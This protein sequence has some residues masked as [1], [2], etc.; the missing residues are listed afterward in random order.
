MVTARLVLH[1]PARLAL[2]R[3]RPILLLA[4]VALGVVVAPSIALAQQLTLSWA[5][6][7]GGQASFIIQRAS[8]TTGPYNQIALVP[9]GITSYIDK[10]VSPGATYCYQVA[11]VAGAGVSPF[12]NVACGSPAAGF[13]VTVAT[14]GTGTG[15]VVSAPAG[16]TCP[17][18]CVQSY[19][20]STVL[21]LT[22]TPAAGSSFTGWSGGGCGGAGSCVLAGNAPV[23]VIATFAKNSTAPTPSIS[24]LNPSSVMAGGPAFSLT[25]TGSGFVSGATATVG[26]QA[27]TVTFGSATQ[28]TIAVSATDI[29]NSGA[30]PVQISNTAPCAGGLC[31]SN[32][33]P[34]TVT[35]PTPAPTLSGISPSTAIAGTSAF[36][37]TATGTNFTTNSVV[38]VN[39][40][41]RTTSFVSA[42]QVTAA[43]LAS[44]IAAAGTASITVVTP[45]PG[46]GTSGAQPLTVLGPSL[47]V[48]AT[49]V[50]PGGTAT[51]TLTNSSGGSTDWLTLAQ[52][53]ATDTSYLQWVYVGA[54]LSTRTW[55]VTMPTTLGQYEFRFYPNN[56]FVR[57]AT[58]P[59]VTVTAVTSTPSV[60]SASQPSVTL[61]VTGNPASGPYAVEA[62]TTL[63]GALTVNFFVDGSFVHQESVAKYCLFGGDG[64]CGTGRLGAGTHVIKA[65]M[66]RQGASTVLAETQITVTEG[67]SSSASAGAVTLVVTGNPASGPYAVEAQS[68]L[69]GPLIMNFLVDG[70]FV[71][72]ESVSKYCLFG[73]DTICSAGTLGAGAHVIKAQALAPGSAAVLAETY[74]TVTE[75]S[76]AP[77]PS[78]V[79]LVVTGNPATGPYAV[80]ARTTLTGALTVNFFVDG[81][82]VHQE[83]IA[84]YCLFGGDTLCGPGRLGAGVHAIKAQ[85]L[86]QGGS[87]VLAETQITVTE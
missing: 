16:I 81:T 36:T 34:L 14:S 87:T 50:A 67:A 3:A 53:G 23:S 8:G 85:V 31:T 26:G 22:A 5:D 80:E 82:F 44:D 35:A 15:T 55:I 57:A 7:S 79:T 41:P 76:S 21:T 68:P 48:N 25:V 9:L 11:A 61:V 75:G 71:H 56:G 6:T 77:P 10:T 62:Q 12:S 73:S 28:L 17:G 37:L 78:P 59:A 13:A 45:A 66:L 24:S 20:T 40:S 4:L 64:T 52:V 42:T 43:I 63:T 39:G 70:S 19:A 27:R 2:E 30:V 51:A 38:R 49:S 72:Q 47:T 65:Q 74:I 29:A 86:K 83:N 84:R 18:T 32:S 46:G 1:Q 60:T 54:G 58:S 69:T 33:V